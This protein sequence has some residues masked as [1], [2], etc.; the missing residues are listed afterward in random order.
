MVQRGVL[1]VFGVSINNRMW[2]ANRDSLAI[3]LVHVNSHVGRFEF[4]AP[5]QS[6]NMGIAG[7]P[8]YAYPLQEPRI[9]K[10]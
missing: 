6:P 10:R 1:N 5:H 8:L 2:L 7:L 9:M 3:L 4:A